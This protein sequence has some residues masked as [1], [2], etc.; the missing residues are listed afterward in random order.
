[1][2]SIIT[3]SLTP[4]FR[5]NVLK[6]ICWRLTHVFNTERFYGRTSREPS[7][8]NPEV[9]YDDVIAVLNRR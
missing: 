5:K 7:R 2:N 1:M 3:Y 8:Q 6:N 9:R 4:Q